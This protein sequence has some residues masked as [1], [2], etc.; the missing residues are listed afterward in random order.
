M[1]DS[2]RDNAD[3]KQAELPEDGPEKEDTAD[4]GDE[5]LVRRRRRDE[6][7]GLI[8]EVGEGDWR[9]RRRRLCQRLRG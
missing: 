8:Y 6:R 4:G 5:E 3:E 7:D 2:T 9:R 1:T